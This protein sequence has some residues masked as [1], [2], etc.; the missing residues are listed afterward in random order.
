MSKHLSPEDRERIN[1]KLREGRALAEELA[2]R[3]NYN[4]RNNIDPDRRLEPERPKTFEDAFLSR[5][6]QADEQ[7][8]RPKR[9]PIIV[10]INVII[11]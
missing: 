5:L 10:R 6:R 3:L 11:L 1:R 4:L 2:A 7:E 9:Q 8:A